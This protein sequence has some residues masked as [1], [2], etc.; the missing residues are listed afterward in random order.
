MVSDSLVLL[1][2]K[3][4]S[5]SSSKS[6]VT[7]DESFK[8][9]LDRPLLLVPAVDG[10]FFL[11]KINNSYCA[12]LSVFLSI[13]LSVCPFFCPSVVCLYICLSVFLYIYLYVC[14]SVCL[15]VCP[16]VVCLYIC[17]SKSSRTDS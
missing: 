3:S 14:V 12:G 6:S 9:N 15:F 2:I 8:D 11:P 1:L 13:Y 7:V 16:S 17:L 4:S 5:I 10:V